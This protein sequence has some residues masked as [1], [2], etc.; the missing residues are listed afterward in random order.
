[1][2]NCKW[3]LAG[4]LVLASWSTQA[5]AQRMSYV[6][7]GTV[8]EV[9][10][11]A[12]AFG[13]PAS[14]DTFT[15]TYL[16][17]F[18]LGYRG[19]GGGQ[20]GGGN[21][22]FGGTSYDATPFKPTIQFS[23]V[24]AV[25]TINGRELDFPGTYAGSVSYFNNA[26]DKLFGGFGRSGVSFVAETHAGIAG[27]VLSQISSSVSS[28]YRV[29]DLVM[30]GIDRPFSLSLDGHD[31]VGLTSFS[32]IWGLGTSNEA[33]ISGTLMPT[34]YTVALAVP[35][36]ATWVLLAIGLAGIAIRACSLSRPLRDSKLAQ[37]AVADM[38]VYS[39]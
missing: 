33:T 17:D 25:L 11:P 36:P 37:S 35:E 10:D 24:S 27:P 7:E 9:S 18:S 23:P 30:E 31:F 21:S 29:V 4:A 28:P 20:L 3:L 5:Q 19:G 22:L 2:K 1:M 32:Y 34:T 15:L 38:P 12:G 8:E 6:L 13:S 26:Y 14:G 16:A 39:R